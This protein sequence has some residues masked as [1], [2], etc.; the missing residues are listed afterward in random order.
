M[1]IIE[2]STETQDLLTRILTE[3]NKSGLPAFS[4]DMIIHFALKDFAT[5]PTQPTDAPS[6]W[7]GT[8]HDRNSVIM[9]T[10]VDPLPSVIEMRRAAEEQPDDH[11]TPDPRGIGRI[12]ELKEILEEMQ[13]LGNDDDW[14]QG[15]VVNPEDS[16]GSDEAS[17]YE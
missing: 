13:P 14:N 8:E 12:R 3:M 5:P 9:W 7:Q 15:E 16:D 11:I 17:N 6:R 10:G 1:P 2:I 4:A